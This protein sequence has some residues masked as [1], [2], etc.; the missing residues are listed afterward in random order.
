MACLSIGNNAL[1]PLRSMPHPA[2]CRWKSVSQLDRDN[3]SARAP[4]APRSAGPVGSEAIR[5]VAWIG[6]AAAVARA[7]HNPVHDPTIDPTI[8]N[9]LTARGSSSRL[10]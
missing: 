2:L 3:A 1:G 4:P 7:R 8:P 9:G 10:K 5:R 6:R